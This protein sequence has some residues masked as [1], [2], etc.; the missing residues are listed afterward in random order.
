MASLIIITLIPAAWHLATAS[1]T[2]GLGGSIND[3]RP[4]N[5]NPERGKLMLEE[6]N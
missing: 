4:T 5:R 1:G 3:I 2:V 6:L